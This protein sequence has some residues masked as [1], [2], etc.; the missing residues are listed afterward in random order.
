MRTIKFRGK[1]VGG[2]EWIVG[3]LNNI[4]GKVFI[5]PRQEDSP[6][7]SPDWFEVNPESVA[8][9][10]GLNENS[11]EQHELNR[12]IFDG[13]IIQFSNGE[14]LAV[15]WNDDTF[16]FQF[17]DGSPINSGERYGTHKH[18]IGNIHD[19]PELLK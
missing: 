16:Q 3:D 18:I 13:D 8:Q 14:K 15:E 6:L 19:N 9:F 11:N 7:N 17:S 4:Y 12:P 10:T 1:R 5:F 2:S